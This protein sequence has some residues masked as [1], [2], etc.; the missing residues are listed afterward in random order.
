M[1]EVLLRPLRVCRRFPNWLDRWMLCRKQMGLIALGLAL[2]HAIYTFI[3]PNRYS[4]KH[5]LISSVVA[6]VW[7][8]GSAARRFHTIAAGQLD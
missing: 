7:P 5:K 1:F 4:V 2:L 3:I 8:S 6:E